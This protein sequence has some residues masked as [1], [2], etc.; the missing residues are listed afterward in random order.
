MFKINYMYFYLNIYD[1]YNFIKYVSNK[2]I[3]YMQKWR[4]DV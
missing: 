3:V 1:L 4:Y 2:V